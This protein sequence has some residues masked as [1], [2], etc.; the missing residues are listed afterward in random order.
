MIIYVFKDRVL[1]YAL[2]EYDRFW[3]LDGMF[4]NVT[5]IPLVSCD[6]NTP[7]NAYTLNW[8]WPNGWVVS[9]TERTARKTDTTENGGRIRPFKIHLKAHYRWWLSGASSLP[10]S[11]IPRQRLLRQDELGHPMC[12]V[13]Y[14]R[15]KARFRMVMPF[16]FW[17]GIG[18]GACCDKE[19]REDFL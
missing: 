3:F 8:K 15:R 6:S 2:I 13:A 4:V 19:Q 17:I 7:S 16:R 11:W 14:C 12:S 18:L 9:S 5:Q 10:W 1:F